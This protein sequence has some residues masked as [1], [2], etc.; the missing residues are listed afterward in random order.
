[1]KVF[2]NLTYIL[3]V[4]ALSSLIGGCGK[5]QNPD[6]GLK[7][8][9]ELKDLSK[10]QLKHFNY[11]ELFKNSGAYARHYGD[12]IIVYDYSKGSFTT[13]HAIF[14][15]TGETTV[16]EYQKLFKKMG[17]AIIKAPIANSDDGYVVKDLK[18]KKQYYVKLSKQGGLDFTYPEKFK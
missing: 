18:Y 6:D 7:F 5:V 12:T 8:R 13:R 14:K 11:N 4:L 9:L 2:F 10:S 15:Y 17:F 16:P 1:M 3:F